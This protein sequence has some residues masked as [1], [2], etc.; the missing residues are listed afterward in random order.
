M[1]RSTLNPWVMFPL[2]IMLVL[3]RQNLEP[4]MRR[5]IDL[6]DSMQNT[7][8]DM[9]KG[10]EMMQSAVYQLMMAPGSNHLP[11]EPSE[12]KLNTNL[13]ADE[14]LPLEQTLNPNNKRPDLIEPEQPLESNSAQGS[15]TPEELGSSPT[16]GANEI[17]SSIEI[18]KPPTVLPTGVPH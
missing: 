6:I 11:Q 2:F 3:G 18:T 12:S 5:L 7:V 10:I 13:P 14:Q 16:S 17:T 9:Q 4:W 15:A 8:I 1:N